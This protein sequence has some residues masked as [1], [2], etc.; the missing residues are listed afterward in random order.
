MLVRV[1]GT[2][3]HRRRNAGGFLFP[4]PRIRCLASCARS[5]LTG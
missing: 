1:T 2:L 3:T 4:P 5:Q